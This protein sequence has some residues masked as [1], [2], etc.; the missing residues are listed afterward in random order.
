LS[1]AAHTIEHSRAVGNRGPDR[2]TS[3]L[4]RRNQRTTNR[5]FSRLRHL[6]RQV[7]APVED[8]H[9]RHGRDRE[10]ARHH[11]AGR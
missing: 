5:F 8:Q 1:G 3:H 10:G 9:R 4:I 2:L 11:A 6:L 7:R